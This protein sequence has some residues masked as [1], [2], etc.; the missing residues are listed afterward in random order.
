MKYII[1]LYFL[2]TIFHNCFAIRNKEKIDS[3]N[4]YWNAI[5]VSSEFMDEIISHSSQHQVAQEYISKEYVS[6][7]KHSYSTED[8]QFYCYRG[9]ICVTPEQYYP[10]VKVGDKGKTFSTFEE[11]TDLIFSSFPIEKATSALRVIKSYATHQYLYDFYH[12]DAIKRY[13]TN[14]FT[15]VQSTFSPYESNFALFSYNLCSPK[16]CIDGL[17]KCSKKKKEPWIEEWQKYAYKQICS[18]NIWSLYSNKGLEVEVLQSKV[19]KKDAF[20]L[21]FLSAKPV[22][23]ELNN[24]QTYISY[25][26]KKSGKIKQIENLTYLAILME[27]IDSPLIPNDKEKYNLIN[28]IRQLREFIFTL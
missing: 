18:C 23:F 4:D 7:F 27:I 14:V 15:A 28:N 1:I 13:Q 5:P 21:I 24:S 26:N 3:I 16:K 8:V 6:L 22:I 20:A 19:G 2:F 10:Y 9:P 17:R 11:L 12:T 25:Q